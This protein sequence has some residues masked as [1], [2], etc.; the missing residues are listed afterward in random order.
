MKKLKSFDDY[1]NEGVLPDWAQP[2]ASSGNFEFPNV[3]YQEY[4][5]RKQ[6]MTNFQ[7]GDEVRCEKPNTPCHDKSGKITSMEGSKYITF[8]TKDGETIEVEPQFLTKNIIEE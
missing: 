2:S 6:S 8:Q 4:R 7:V 5:D 1:I 3:N